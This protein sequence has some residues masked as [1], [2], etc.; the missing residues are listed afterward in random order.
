MCVLARAAVTIP[1]AERARRDSDANKNWADSLP[2]TH[3]I[4]YVAVIAMNRAALK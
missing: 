4:N 2:I 1:I 3:G